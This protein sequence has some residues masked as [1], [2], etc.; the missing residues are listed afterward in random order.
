M[1]TTQA[2][3]ANG[4]ASPSA[5]AADRPLTIAGFDAELAAAA[6][7]A[8]AIAAGLDD[9]TGRARPADGGWSVAE[10][11]THLAATTRVYLPVLNGAI[12]RAHGG[13]RVSDRPFRLGIVGRWMVATMEPPVHRRLSAP[14]TIVPPS[15]VPLADALR[16]FLTTQD[17]LRRCV[18]AAAGLDLAGVRVRSPLAPILRLSLGTCFA[19]I[20]AHE[21]RH[22]WQARRV[23]D[24]LAGRAG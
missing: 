4:A 18:S 10:C 8:Q 6:A 14:R 2:S 20:T 24:E 15:D 11:L 12:A 3:P 23:R 16:D 9:A 17:E 7:D 21:R 13:G 19:V 5:G 1:T 22:L